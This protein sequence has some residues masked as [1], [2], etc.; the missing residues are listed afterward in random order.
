MTTLSSPTAEILGSNDLLSHKSTFI[1][2]SRVSPRARLRRPHRRSTDRNQVVLN[3]WQRIL[4]TGRLAGTGYTSILPVDQGIEHSAGASF[5]PNPDYFDPTR[6]SSS[7]I[8][9]G[10]NAVASTYGVLGIRGPQVRPQ[11]PLHRQVQPQRAA[12]LPQHL[13]PDP[14]RQHPQAGRWARRRR[15]DD[16]LRLRESASRSS[17][18]RRD[19]RRGPR[20]GHGHRPLV[21]HRN[22][23]FKVNGG[24]YHTAAD[25]T[26]QANHL[27]VTI[28]AD[29]VKQ[30][31]PTNNGGYKALNTG[32]S[33]YG[34][35]DTRRST[36]SSPAATRTA[37]RPPHRPLPLPDR[38]LLHGPRPPDQLGRRQLGRGR[39]RRTPSPPRSSTSGPAAWASSRAARPSSAR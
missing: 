6:S 36:P 14:L 22:N 3:N 9:G 12:D 4:N 29:I 32:D 25:L 10:C 24:D 18:R 8:E 38:Q 15:R 31:L 33:S 34:K 27:G 17:V 11:D 21:L 28:Q 26:G 23:A 19:V 30:K 16:L 37:G 39:P 20:A 7:P 1:D 5:A 35:F 13:Q 2:K